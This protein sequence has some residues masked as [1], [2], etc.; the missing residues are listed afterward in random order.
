MYQLEI[1][2]IS[3]AV[4]IRKAL[5]CIN[6]ILQI[7]NLSMSLGV[8]LGQSGVILYA[9]NMGITTITYYREK[10]QLVFF[11]FPYGSIIKTR[12]SYRFKTRVRFPQQIVQTPCV[13][14]ASILNWLFVVNRVRY[15]YGICAAEFV[16]VSRTIVV[17][18][19]AE[20][21]NLDR[22]S[23]RPAVDERLYVNAYIY[24]YT[25]TCIRDGPRTCSNV[26][27]VELGLM[28]FCER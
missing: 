18:F 11:L 10:N 17:Q 2:Y 13:R 8:V 19:S 7:E 4:V 12:K 24:V 15:S 9:Y 14:Y 27:L 6:V 5:K 16:I 20:F 1:I 28:A 22:V 3:T 21:A 26:Y 23:K 25:Y